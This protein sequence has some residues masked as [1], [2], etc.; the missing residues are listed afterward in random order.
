MARQPRLVGLL[1]SISTLPHPEYI[2]QPCFARTVPVTVGD[3]VGVDTRGS[4][5]AVARGSE[6]RSPCRIAPPYATRRSYGPQSMVL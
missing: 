6:A 5:T 2:P 4:S 3:H 1:A